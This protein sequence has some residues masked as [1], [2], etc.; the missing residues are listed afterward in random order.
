MSVNRLFV[1]AVLALMA[2]AAHAEEPATVAPATTQEAAPVEGA[3][4]EGVLE[5]VTREQWAA[6]ARK[7]MEETATRLKLTE[8]QKRK[9]QP[10]FIDPMAKFREIAEERQ[11][12]SRAEMFSMMREVRALR[13]ETEA[14]I[15]PL[16]N[17]AQ[18]Q[19]AAKMR[20]ERQA[21][22]QQAMQMWRNGDKEGARKLLLPELEAPAEKS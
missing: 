3:G 1:A 7:R 13:E 18:R 5:D 11:G 21:R 19:E 8:E 2:T 22:N 16:L 9:L 4:A 14:R 12:A 10:V 20:E 6:L 17:E 15:E